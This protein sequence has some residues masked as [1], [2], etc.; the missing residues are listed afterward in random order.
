VNK[1]VIIFVA[2]VFELAGNFSP[3]LFGNND[4]FSLWAI[5]GG[6]IGGLFG[7]WVGVLVSKRFF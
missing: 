5:L 3:M 2:I 6:L 1:H 4:I 7:V